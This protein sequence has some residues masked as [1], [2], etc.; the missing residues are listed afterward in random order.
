[1]QLLY[2]NCVPIFT[3]GAS[4]LDLSASEKHQLSVAVNNAVRKIFGFCYWQSIR[5]L[6]DFYHFDSIE[7]M[8]AKAR[9]RFLKSIA[10]HRN[11]LLRFLYS[12]VVVE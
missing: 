11:S 1:M 6:R 2:S 7:V 12:V 8:F 5:Q 9:K 10:N 3:Y 4:V